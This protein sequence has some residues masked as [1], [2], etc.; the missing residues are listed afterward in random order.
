MVSSPSVR[1][2]PSVAVLLLNGMRRLPLWMDAPLAYFVALLCLCYKFYGYI[3]L[4]FTSKESIVPLV[5]DRE[6][7]VNVKVAYERV[8]MEIFGA[9]STDYMKSQSLL[10]DKLRSNV[11]MR[12]TVNRFMT[13]EGA[14]KE[15]PNLYKTFE[16]LW[17]ALLEFPRKENREYT[18]ELSL[19][20][21]AYRESG[22]ELRRT[23][24]HALTACVEPSKVQVLIVDCGRCAFL[25]RCLHMNTFGELK[26]VQ[27]KGQGGR[28]PAMNFGT[29]YAKGRIL[30]FLHSDTLIPKHWDVKV[31]QALQP[32]QVQASVFWVGHDYSGRQRERRYPWGLGSVWIIANIRTLFFRLPYGDHVISMRHDYF[33]HVGGYPEQPIMEDYELMQLLRQRACQ[34]KGEH[35]AVIRPPTTRCGVRRWQKHGVAYT[36]AVNSWIVH[37]Y[38]N[39]WTADQVYEYYYGSK[40]NE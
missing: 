13:A 9:T 29:Q 20:V 18:F 16:R 14:A 28:G 23:L 39:G 36:T 3:I 37:Q 2:P 10:I 25:E 35:I 32:K 38:Q 17:P 19:V 27:Y 22:L 40:K 21:P 12:R 15:Y 30:V 11:E 34:R 5:T 26:I 4:K 7:N 6:R 33:D 1:K 24:Q 31:T 8:M